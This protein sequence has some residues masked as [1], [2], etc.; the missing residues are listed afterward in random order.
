MPDIV[1]LNSALDP[2]YSSLLTILNGLAEQMRDMRQDLKD[3]LKETNKRISAAY[4]RIGETNERIGRIEVQV[5]QVQSDLKTKYD[6]L[7]SQLNG[8]EGLTRRVDSLEATR[9]QEKGQT[10]VKVFLVRYV[11]PVAIS[12]VSS[13]LGAWWALA[14]FLI[15]GTPHQ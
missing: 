3:D 13:I 1:H 4:D 9:D 5:T 11:L 6:V 15:P 7:E 12:T 14:K 2:A 10:T 8:K